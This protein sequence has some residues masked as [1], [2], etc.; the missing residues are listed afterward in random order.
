[1][2]D[3]QQPRDSVIAIVIIVVVVVVVGI[4][5]I[6]LLVIIISSNS[7]T[8]SRFSSSLVVLL[9]GIHLGALRSCI[10]M[11]LQRLAFWR[12]CF[13]YFCAS[14]KWIVQYC[15]RSAWRD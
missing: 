1:M 8:G 6:M 11:L 15:L 3:C 13:M 4:V 7:N 14:R 9:R 12:F 5:I 10:P 2:D